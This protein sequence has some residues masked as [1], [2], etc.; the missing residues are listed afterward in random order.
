MAA[1]RAPGR[2]I[3][4]NAALEPEVL[5]LIEALTKM[6]ARITI[7]A[8]AHIVVDGVEKLNPIEHSIIVDRLEAGAL[9]LAGA[10]TGGEVYL[11]DLPIA[12]V[13]VF[14]EKLKQMGHEIHYGSS[15][16]GV[17]IKGTVHPRAVSFKTGPHPSFPTDLQA[18][19]TA[20]LAVASGISI[21]EETVFENR[22]LHVFELHKMGAQI[23]VE[24]TKAI[25]RGVDQLYGSSVI[26]TDIRA[27]CALVLAG[28]I[29]QGNTVMSGLHHW[30]R[31]YDGLE[32]K[33]NSLGARIQIVHD[34]LV[35]GISCYD[36]RASHE[37]RP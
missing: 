30:R 7:Q 26:A 36:K 18:P 13:D 4:V 27:S 6:G 10:I 17:R 31:G 9:L 19:M 37:P 12:T 11:P 16:C 34:E 32:H 28:L 3:L 29:A 24:H 20:A 33:L 2:T 5:D 14:L 1:V 15:G 8:P 22:L 21:V 25:V 35:Q 23:T